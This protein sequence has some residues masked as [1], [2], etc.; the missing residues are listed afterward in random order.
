MAKGALTKA[1]IYSTIVANFMPYPRTRQNQG[2]SHMSLVLNQGTTPVGIEVKTLGFGEDQVV[3]LGDYEIAMADFCALT[4]YVLT[5]TDLVGD[6][7]PRL[8][9]IEEM[10]KLEKVPGYATTG[11][12]PNKKA[13]RLGTAEKPAEPAKKTRKKSRK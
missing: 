3:H 4:I 11:I 7:D 8:A 5:N 2:E 13:L 12:P 9:L 6:K 1:I 10:R